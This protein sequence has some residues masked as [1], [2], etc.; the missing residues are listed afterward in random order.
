MLSS[1]FST[2]HEG[3]S[4]IERFLGRVSAHEDRFRMALFISTAKLITIATVI[5]QL[6]K[7]LLTYLYFQGF[8]SALSS[9]S[10][11]IF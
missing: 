3:V 2:V 5:R 8:E 6:T 10:D 11:I 1:D 9:E 7:N 4:V